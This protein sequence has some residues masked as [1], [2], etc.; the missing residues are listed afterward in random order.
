[1]VDSEAGMT[2]RVTDAESNAQV[3]VAPVQRRRG[4]DPCATVSVPA[5]GVYR[6]TVAGGGYSPV[7]HLTLAFAE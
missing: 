3:A 2:C 6:I 7:E 5:P 4:A 1:V